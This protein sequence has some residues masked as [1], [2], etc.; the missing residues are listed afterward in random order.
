MNST[1]IFRRDLVDGAKIG[2]LTVVE[3]PKP[4]DRRAVFRCACGTARAMLVANVLAGR[5]RSCGCV[6]GRKGENLRKHGR[7]RSPEYVAWCNAKARCHRKNH[8]R[9]A[10][11][12]G[13]GISM[14]ERWRDDFAA[15]LADMGPRPSP[16]HSIDRIDNDGPY[17]PENCRWATAEQQS[18][19]RPTWANTITFRGETLT[20]TQWAPRVGITRK[21]LEHRLRAGWSI[22]RALT[23]PKGGA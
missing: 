15:F 10:E 23:T 11:W 13:R 14:C 16:G 7:A 19:N 9:Y 1:K 3:P 6:V 8:P 12:G 17:S 20:L 18:T 2:A 22:E 21:S 5:T 4:G